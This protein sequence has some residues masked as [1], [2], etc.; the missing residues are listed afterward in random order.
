MKQAHD[1]FGD[2]ESFVQ[3]ADL[4]LTAKVKLQ[5][6]FNNHSTKSQLMVELAKLLMSQL[7][8]ELAITVDVPAHGRAC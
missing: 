6:I 3:T 4:S 8:V 7:M 2:V 5:Q 1:L